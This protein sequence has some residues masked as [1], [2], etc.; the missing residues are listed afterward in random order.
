VGTGIEGDHAQKIACR[1]ELRGD[2]SDYCATA[3]AHLAPGGFFA[4]VFPTVQLS[5]VEIAAAKA[6]LT[7][8]RRRPVVLKDGEESLISLFGMGVSEHL[9]ASFRKQTWTEPPLIIR[10]KE[11]QVHPEYAA[12]K[13]SVGFPP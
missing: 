12:V 4:C 3:A 1:F 6:G 9:P 11:G 5:R 2:I 8:I 13:L 7:I 10:Q